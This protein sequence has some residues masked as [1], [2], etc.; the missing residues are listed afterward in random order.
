M[1]R[2]RR[3]T[4]TLVA[5][6]LTVASGATA[7]TAR[8]A[9]SCPSTNNYICFWDAANGTPPDFWVSGRSSIPNLHSGGW[10]DRISS[11]WN[12]SGVRYCGYIDANYLG[13]GHSPFYM[14]NGAR[15]TVLALWN[16]RISSIRPC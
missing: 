6:L 15:G 10:G 3:L 13:G 5:T 16:N 1:W 12:R 8:A 4:A 2:S 11:Y 9:W 7:G 14:P